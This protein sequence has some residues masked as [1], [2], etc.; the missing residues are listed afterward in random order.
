M[1]FRNIVFHQYNLGSWIGAFRTQFANAQFYL[2]LIQ[3]FLVAITAYDSVF[4]KS[5]LRLWIPIMTMGLFLL[6]FLVFQG[7]AMWLDYKFV[8]PAVISFNNKQAYQHENP[9]TYWLGNINKRLDKLDNI[10]KQVIELQKIVGKMS[11]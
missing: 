9:V 2:S 11:K 8:L 10:E 7:L 1:R 6:I 5:T 4:I 3:F